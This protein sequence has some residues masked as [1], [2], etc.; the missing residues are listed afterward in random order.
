MCMH[1]ALTHDPLH[2]FL[3]AVGGYARVPGEDSAMWMLL[4]DKLRVCET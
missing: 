1:L 3:Q 2:T 4:L